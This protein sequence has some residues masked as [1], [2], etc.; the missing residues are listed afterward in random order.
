M[1]SGRGVSKKKTDVYKDNKY[2]SKFSFTLIK[3]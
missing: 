1:K 3:I 2:V